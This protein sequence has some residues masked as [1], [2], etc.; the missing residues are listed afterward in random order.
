VDIVVQGALD[1]EL[2]LL[3]AS[4]EG[5]EQIQIAAW[6]FWCGRIGTSG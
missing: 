3:L 4:L 2:Q 1:S 6:T 5:S